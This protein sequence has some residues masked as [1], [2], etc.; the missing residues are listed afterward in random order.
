MT[1][2]LSIPR[3]LDRGGVADVRGRVFR[4]LRISLIYNPG[5]PSERGDYALPFYRKRERVPL[6]TLVR[7]GSGGRVELLW[8]PVASTVLR[9]SLL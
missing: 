5:L 7:C 1:I 2:E 3:F 6:G 8:S 9:G 4:D